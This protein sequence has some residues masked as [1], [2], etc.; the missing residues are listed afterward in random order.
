MAG[1]FF[2]KDVLNILWSEVNG[3]LEASFFTSCFVS[4]LELLMEKYPSAT[5]IVFWTNSCPYQNRN[6]KIASALAN[7]SKSHKITIYQKYLEVVHTHM[8]CDSVNSSVEK[9]NKNINLPAGYIRVNKGSRKN[10]YGVKYC[11]LS[12]FKNYKAICDLPPT[13]PVKEEGRPYIVD[14]WQLKYT[15]D[16]TIYTNLIKSRES[17]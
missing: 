10:R 11:E 13:K 8:E 3:D 15:P 17:A 6:A 16:G 2:D 7:F 4:Y 1:S 9:A 12:F 14:I 5:V